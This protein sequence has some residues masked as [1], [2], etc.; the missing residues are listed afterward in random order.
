[1]SFSPRLILQIFIPNQIEY[2][3]AKF[4]LYTYS[5]LL[6]I[7]NIF[8]FDLGFKFCRNARYFVKLLDAL[9]EIVNIKKI[10]EALSQKYESDF[11]KVLTIT[12]TCLISTFIIDSLDLYLNSKRNEPRA[13]RTHHI[14]KLLFFVTAYLFISI[15]T[16]AESLES[17]SFSKNI[18]ET[19]II[20]V[21]VFLAFLDI[22]IKDDS[23]FN[24]IDIIFPE[25]DSYV[26]YQQREDYFNF[27]QSLQK[28][29]ELEQFE[30]S[31][32]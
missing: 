1:M 4:I 17:F 23:I 2:G 27:L 31:Q 10:S 3:D 9:S 24:S 8:P 14:K 32:Q 13:Y 19:L 22:F 11:L 7:Y 15:P 12:M 29:E 6:A 25:P 21:Y 26:T 5:I 16:I 28:R 18:T 30:K 20:C